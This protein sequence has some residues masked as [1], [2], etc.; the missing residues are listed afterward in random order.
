MGSRSSLW[1]FSTM[2]ISSILWSEAERMYAGII[3]IPAALQARK[4]RSPL[5]IWYLSSPVL[6]TVMGWIRPRLRMDA[7]SS[8]S[9]SVSNDIRG[10]N[11]LGS[12][13]SAGMR[14]MSALPSDAVRAPTI[15]LLT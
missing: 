1:M 14:T 10:W 4:R 6:R 11:G 7:V 9:A 2:A 5:M 15:S 12:I 8:S 13:R 3:S